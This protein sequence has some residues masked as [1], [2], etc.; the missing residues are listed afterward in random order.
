MADT[1]ASNRPKTMHHTNTILQFQVLVESEP[2][3]RNSKFE[4]RSINVDLV[5]T[6]ENTA[7][8][9]FMDVIMWIHDDRRFYF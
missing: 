7:Y 8:S 3:H 6:A 9:M 4:K 1:S 5:N 2:K